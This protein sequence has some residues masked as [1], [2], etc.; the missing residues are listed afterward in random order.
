M[1]SLRHEWSLDKTPFCKLLS[2]GKIDSL[3]CKSAFGCPSDRF[4]R[5]IRSRCGRPQSVQ[6]LSRGFFALRF[7]RN[8]PLR[9]PASVRNPVA[10]MHNDLV[11]GGETGQNLG[12]AII[13]MT[14][15]DRERPGA[16]VL[17]GENGPVLAL[18][19]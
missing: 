3:V 13:P 17:N 12:C 19:E 4:P 18:P 10:G 11:P 2:V 15:P 9:H 1:T 5:L 16:P 14:D 8:F 6:L 7:L